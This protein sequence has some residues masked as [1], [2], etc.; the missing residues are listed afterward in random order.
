M[1][2]T[3][4]DVSI[5]GGITIEPPTDANTSQADGLKVDKLEVKYNLK[6]YTLFLVEYYDHVKLSRACRKRM[7]AT[8]VPPP[9]LVQPQP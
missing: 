2:D 7:K 1:A 4:L 9:L 3:E 5:E 8:L 6:T